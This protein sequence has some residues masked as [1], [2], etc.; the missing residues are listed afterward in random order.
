M[1]KWY[2]IET[3]GDTFETE[4]SA[5]T[6]KD[7]VA[8]ALA[9]WS[10]LSGFDKARRVEAYIIHADTVDG[11]IDYESADEYVGIKGNDNDFESLLYKAIAPDADQ[12]NIDALG[13]WFE[14]HGIS[15]WNG[16][17]YDASA[18]DEP[19]GTRRLRPLYDDDEEIVGY[20][21]Y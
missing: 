12:G 18:P 10:R 8:E 21:F 6:K 9:I 2:F 15:C 4:L 7:A 13:A 3:C 14:R 20:E 17:Y 19:S 1:K 16:E 11:C 5:A